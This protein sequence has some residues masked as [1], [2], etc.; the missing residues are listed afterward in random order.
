MEKLIQFQ[1]RALYRK[2]DQTVIDQR[3]RELRYCRNSRVRSWIAED[4]TIGYI[5]NAEPANSFFH[6]HL[7]FAGDDKK[8]HS[9]K[10]SMLGLVA[11]TAYGSV[12]A[13][14]EKLDI[15]PS[16]LKKDRCT[17]E[18]EE[19]VRAAERFDVYLRPLLDSKGRMTRMT[20]FSRERSLRTQNK[21]VYNAFDLKIAYEGTTIKPKTVRLLEPNWNAIAQWTQ[22]LI[23][24]ANNKGREINPV[25]H[26]VLAKFGIDSAKIIRPQHV[27]AN[28][29]TSSR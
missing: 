5:E 28:T 17:W 6:Q 15:A 20:V 11:N 7:L 3:G 29:R 13:C 10:I 18:D 24:A 12:L 1:S 8:Y 2:K 14:Y 16:L 19:S 25:V 26:E 21:A 4:R 27:R 9:F 23:G 22:G